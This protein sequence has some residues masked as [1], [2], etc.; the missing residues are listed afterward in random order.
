MTFPGVSGSISPFHA[1]GRRPDAL[2]LQE[3][4]SPSEVRSR[5]NGAVEKASEFQGA[6]GAVDSGGWDGAGF[7]G[8]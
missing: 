1:F 2:G 3:C 7:S 4:D 6:Q 8:G 5:T